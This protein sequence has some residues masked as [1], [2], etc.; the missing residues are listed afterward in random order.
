MTK[1]IKKQ[2]SNVIGR[3]V[4]LFYI[5]LSILIL[6]SSLYIFFIKQTIVNVVERERFTKESRLLSSE[7]GDLESK[8]IATKSKITLEY[9]KSL[10]FVDS[11]KTNYITRKNLS[12]VALVQS[13]SN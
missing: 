12:K 8:Y 9:A 2:I 11:K 7:L 1:L 3:E 10:G 5:L 6:F 13:H 4:H